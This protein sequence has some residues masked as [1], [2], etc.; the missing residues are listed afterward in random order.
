MNTNRLKQIFD[1]YR[2]G[3]VQISGGAKGDGQ[4]QVRTQKNAQKIA[5]YDMGFARTQFPAYMNRI[6]GRQ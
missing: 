5:V 6:Y 4:Y 3:V 2:N 1:T